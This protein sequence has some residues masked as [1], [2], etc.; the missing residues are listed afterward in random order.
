MGR[1]RL[2]PIQEHFEVRTFSVLESGALFGEPAFEFIR[3]HGM[4]VKHLCCVCRVWRQAKQR[5][6]PGKCEENGLSGKGWERGM[7]PDYAGRLNQSVGMEIQRF[8]I[9]NRRGW[10]WR[11]REKTKRCRP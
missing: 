10:I 9:L 4:D 2:A 1:H 3:I 11:S 5:T 7:E 8:W 6:T